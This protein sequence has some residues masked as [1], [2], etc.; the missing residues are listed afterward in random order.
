MSLANV[1]ASEREEVGEAQALEQ[2]SA[3]LGAQIQ[4]AQAAAPPPSSTSGSTPSASAVSFCARFDSSALCAP[5]S[6]SRTARTWSVRMR[7]T[8][9]ARSTDAFVFAVCARAA[10]TSRLAPPTSAAIRLSW[11][12]IAFT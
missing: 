11:V 7:I 1:R 3:Q 6:W 9:V 4:A 12:P 8:A 2:V 10:A 5:T